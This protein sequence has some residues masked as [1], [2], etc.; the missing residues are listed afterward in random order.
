MRVLG[1]DRSCL[2]GLPVTDLGPCLPEGR[3][4]TVVVEEGGKVVGSMTVALV[5]HI[6]A[7]WIDPEH[8][9]AG[10]ARALRRAT[11]ELAR[12]GGATWAFGSAGDDATAATLV[13]LGGT[14]VPVTFYVLPLDRRE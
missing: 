13:R 4:Q 1:E 12:D 7:T 2:A 6:E 14:P 9:N 3:A 8:R 5:P 10:V 11:W